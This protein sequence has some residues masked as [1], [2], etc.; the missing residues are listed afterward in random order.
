MQIVG[1]GFDPKVLADQ[2]GILLQLLMSCLLLFWGP[3]P[4]CGAH[5]VQRCLTQE[6]PHL[7][8]SS[9]MQNEPAAFGVISKD[10]QRPR[11]NPMYPLLHCPLISFLYYVAVAAVEVSCVGE[12]L[13]PVLHDVAIHPGEVAQGSWITCSCSAPSFRS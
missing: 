10:V 6:S 9:V 7:A 1:A 11:L 5:V 12:M 13:G 4:R 8:Q 2:S 3:I